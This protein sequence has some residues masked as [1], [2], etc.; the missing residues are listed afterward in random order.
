MLKTSLRSFF[1]HKGRMA[2]SLIAV[3]LS[4]AFV[5][6][7][8]VFT[9][10]VDR[11]FSRL[12]AATSADV[13]ISPSTPS[14]SSG[15][16]VYTKPESVPGSMV[17]QV[18]SLP[19]VKDAYGEVDSESLAVTDAAGNQ[20]GPSGGAPTI[21]AN[22]HPTPHSVVQLT[23][24]QA[25]QGAEQVVVDASTA[26]KDHLVIGD[27]LSLVTETGD[28]HATISGIATF[29]TTN[30]GAGLFFFDTAT[31]QRLLLGSSTAFSD[32][33]IDTAPGYTDAQVQHSVEQLL[34]ANGTSAT[35]STSSTSGAVYTVQTKAQAAAADQSDLGSFLGV[36][37][38]AMLGFAAIAV[39]V[40][41]F[42]IFNTFSMLVAQRTRQL[43]LLRAIGASRRQVNRSVLTEALLLGV[44]GSTLGIAAGVGL[45][46]GL[47]KLMALTGMQL[48]LSQLDFAWSTPVVGYTVGI[49]VTLVSG[50][51]PARRASRVSPMAAMRDA[52]TPSERR[53][54]IVRSAVGL[55][56][57]AGG[58]GALV[59]A[60]TT[61]AA[62]T[63]G[64]YLA[65][66]VLLTLL[67]AVV[68]G[69]LLAALVVR[70]LGSALPLFFGPVGRLA[71]RNALRNP[72]RTGATAAALMIGLALVAGLSVVGSSIVSS[73]DSQ[74]SSSV[75]ADF[76]VIA[77][78][79]LPVTAPALQAVRQTPGL[80]HVT[81]QKEVGLKL[82]TPDGK[83]TGETVPASDATFTQDYRMDTVSGSATAIYTD[84]GIS[85]TQ[86]F[87]T[88]HHLTVG[89]DVTVTFPGGRTA[90]V[91]VEAI[92]KNTGSL[93]NGAFFIGLDTV[94][95]YTPA[96]EMPGDVMLY[97]STAQGASADT[98][99][100]AL[101]RELRPYPQL[102]VK[103]QADYKA[104][105]QSQISGILN[106][107][108]GLLAL[109]IVVAVLGVVNT[110]AL[111]VVER[112]REIGL[113]R[114]I[115]LSRRQLRRMIRLESV[116]IALFGAVLG[117]GLGLGWGVVAQRLLALEGMTSLSIPWPTIAGVFIGSAVVGM[118][119]AL[120][121]A[122]RAARMNVLA[123][124]ASD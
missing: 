36:M 108:Y 25:P 54:S 69:P 21:G 59:A 73:V 109:A 120:A 104:Q 79:G 100:S 40:G 33:A 93:F 78:G 124:I 99:Y 117:L 50:Y 42:L 6:G 60:A 110:L 102:M 11:T 91:P 58:V 10:T 15:Q 57:A 31:A 12:F 85:V 46:V 8:L 67:A 45:A 103:N 55:L 107:V 121:P 13:T 119:A 4:V 47:V 88:D 95:Q 90:P 64:V 116:V 98:A 71:Q 113:I 53:A 87:A 29:T 3:M 74:V 41:I 70:V 68:L 65:G 76:V 123:A 30:P 97:A 9:D 16:S 44:V 56:L 18:S 89:Q 27:Q 86:S 105:V 51:L 84:H 28:Y 63:A 37:K 94:R 7:T 1:A 80:S 83:T 22:W 114:A 62:G 52:G 32:V 23:S 2:L 38:D 19:G 24:G 96:A 20:V 5:S 61:H 82:T 106:L 72:R 17:G 48:D 122:F 92:S 14:S 75:G 77:N 34:D 43:G 35:S 66:G 111:S 39:L 81:E 26:S 101:K 49:L 115:G 112:T 118:L